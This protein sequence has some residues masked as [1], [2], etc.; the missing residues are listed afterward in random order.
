MKSERNIRFICRFNGL[1][2]YLRRNKPKNM[3]ESK[4]TEGQIRFMTNC[5]I[6]DITSYLMQDFK[7]SLEEALDCIYNSSL[8]EKLTDTATGLYYQS[9]AYNY[10]LLKNEIRFGKFG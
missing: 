3:E 9:S 6:K 1:F 4:L 8:Y 5:R 10:E 2:V 7:Y